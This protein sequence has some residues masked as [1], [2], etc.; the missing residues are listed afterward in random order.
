MRTFLHPLHPLRAL[1]LVALSILSLAALPSVAL[2]KDGEPAKKTYDLPAGDAGIRLKQ[3]SEIS[4]RETLFAA[5][6]VRGVRTAAIKGEFTPVE[7]LTR[8]L[9]GTGLVLVQDEKTGALGVKRKTEKTESGAIRLATVTVLGTR[10]RQTESEGPSPVSIYD[11]EYIRAT[12]AMTLADFLNYLPQTYSGIAAGRGSAPNELNPEFGQRTE[13][14]FP[15]FNFVLGASDAPPGQTG[16]SGVSLRGLGSGSTLVLIDGRR[17]AKSGSGNRSTSSQQG[18]VDLNTIPLGM[19]DHIEVITDGASAIYGADAVAGVI[20]VVLKRNWQGNELSSSYRASA[21]GGGRERQVTLTTGFAAGKLS[22]SVAVDYYDRGELKASDRSFSKNQDHRGVIATYDANG[23]PVYGRDLR[24]L[25]G[26]PGVVQARTGTLNGITDPAVN[27]T[28]FAVINPGVTGTP[29]LSSFTGAFPGQ[30]NGASYI[31]RA[32]TAQFLDLIP[33]SERYGVTGNFTYKIN[34]LVEA[35]GTYSFSD[36]RGLFNTQPG[37]TS[38]STFNGFGNFASIVP[39]AYNPFGQDIAVGLVDY[40]FGSVWQKTHTKAHNGL[41]GV[42]GKVG[43]TWQWDTGL[44]FQHQSADQLTRS[45][46]G[47][48]ITAALANTDPA[49]RLNPFIDARVA[50]ITQA[51]IYEKMAYYPSRDTSSEARTWDF[52]ADGNLFDLPGGP[53]KMAFGG[54]YNRD[55]VV[56]DVLNYSTGFS[57]LVASANHVQATGHNYAVFGEFSVPVFGKPNALPL[58]RRL[59]LDLAGRYE[60]YSTA[61]GEAVPKLGISWVPVKPL[62]LRAGYSEGFRPPGLTEHLV[63]PST[64][65]SGSV[66][67]PRRTPATTTGIL[68]TTGTDPVMNSETSKTEF[69]GLVFEP[70]VIKGLNFQVNY[71]RTTQHNVIQTLSPQTLVNNE[72][73]FAN[74]ITRAA[75]TAADLALNQPGQ[76]TAIDQTFINFG[77]VVNESVDYMVDYALP[78]EHLGRWRISF[79]ATQT[80]ASTRELAPGKPPVVDDGDTFAPPKWKFIGSLFWNR[81]SWNASSFVSYTGGFDTNQAGNSLTFTYPVPSVYKVDVHAGYEFKHGVWRGYGKNLRVQLGI[82]NVFDKKPPFSDTVFGYNGGLHSQLALGRA[83]EFS[84]VMPF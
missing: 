40:E 30:T 56:S 1:T 9:E 24:L 63:A 15:S 14:S 43:Q 25:W 45:F 69:Y 28:R 83:Y 54:T 39:A 17:A 23:N 70:P 44:N 50:G 16:V 84:F 72:A 71:Y 8:M 59:D 13:N 58:L 29:T 37:V 4:G 3:F 41:L 2:A 31:Q 81:G 38:A 74:R 18:F 12:G 75:P 35:Y 57:G 46:D 27:P 52:S 32:N 5:E 48:G 68:V 33:K 60:S 6:T 67:D 66:T 53:V 55:A 51:A 7:A 42:R 10:I 73:L 62:L 49:Q 65:A 80:L 21:H 11:S 20:N 64:S 76:I 26:Y 82:N 22:G 34:D 79:D 19:I 47:S 36:T 78:A 61:N 77:K